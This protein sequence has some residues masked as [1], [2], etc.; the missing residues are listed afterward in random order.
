MT[1]TAKNQLALVKDEFKQY[2]RKSIEVAQA[3]RD[4]V[5]VQAHLGTAEAKSRWVEIEK[6]L[7]HLDALAHELN[8]AASDFVDHAIETIHGRAE[9]RGATQRAK[10]RAKVTANR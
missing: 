6:R 8:H 3:L 9:Q 5:R 7:A 2:V 1:T 4:E 10:K